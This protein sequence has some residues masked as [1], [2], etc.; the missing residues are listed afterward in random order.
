MMDLLG[1]DKY[2]SGQLHDFDLPEEDLQKSLEDI[3]DYP[4]PQA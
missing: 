3:K 4:K 2:M 1:Y